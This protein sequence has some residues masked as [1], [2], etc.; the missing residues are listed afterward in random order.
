M[1]LERAEETAARELAQLLY[2]YTEGMYGACPERS[3]RE[4]FDRSSNVDLAQAPF[5]VFGLRDV[6][7]EI[8]GPVL[9]SS[10]VLTVNSVEGLYLWLITNLV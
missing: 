7:R 6:A 5:I 4:V 8:S 3:R 1:V 9:S 2:I 10:A